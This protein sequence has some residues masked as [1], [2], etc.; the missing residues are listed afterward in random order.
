[1]IRRLLTIVAIVQAALALGVIARLARTANGRRIARHDGSALDERVTVLVP[2]LNEA[3]RLA[4]CLE[5]LVA[6]GPE[7]AEILVIDGGSTDG[8]P[9]LVRRYGARDPRVRLV[10]ARPVPARRN[11]KAHGLQVGLGQGDPA[12]GWVL[13]IDADVRPAPGLVPAL[14]AQARAGEVPALSAATRQRLSGAAE[15]IIHP[16][17]LATLVYR[18]GIPGHA[19][20]DA[21]R[22]QANGQ[23][24]L[25]RR[26]VRE[27]I[28]GFAVGLDSVCEDVTVARAIA[29]AG[30]PVG[31]YETDDLVDVE[32]YT[33]PREAWDNWTRSL[34][35]KDRFANGAGP[36]RMAEIVLVQG[37]PLP[38]APL[39]GLLAGRRHPATIVN[40]ALLCTRFGVLAGMARAYAGRPATYWLSPL[41]DLPVALRLWRMARRRHHPWR[42]RA[43]VAGDS[44]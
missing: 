27:G 35:M 21:G 38:L 2:V 10:D 11:G 29:A 14:L 40:V 1:M 37:L 23:C 6:Q 17:M 31:F 22:V 15:G 28:G 34:P 26:D 41:A 25:A 24:F 33:G 16:A 9:D 13:T 43:L 19:T 42:G 20:A 39:A 4:P 30:H 3:A 18:Y 12:T 5:G 36:V 7:V 8:T 32:M 44:A